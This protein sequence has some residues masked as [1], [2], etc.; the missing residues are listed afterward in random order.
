MY[1]F[2][3]VLDFKL[4][5]SGQ[6]QPTC[7]EP[8][9]LHEFRVSVNFEKEDLGST[10]KVVDD[11]VISSIEEIFQTSNRLPDVWSNEYVAEQLFTE[12]AKLSNTVKSVSVV[13]TDEPYKIGSYARPEITVDPHPYLSEM[14]VTKA[15]ETGNL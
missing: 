13:S 7:P 6:C 2:S 3:V 4:L 5:H 14:M 11:S 1:H 9:H 10:L 12:I 15:A 8:E